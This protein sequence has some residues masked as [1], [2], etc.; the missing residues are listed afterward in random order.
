MSARYGLTLSDRAPMTSQRNREALC[1]RQSSSRHNLPR[2]LIDPV[3]ALAV[4]L[5]PRREMSVGQAEHKERTACKMAVRR[6][7]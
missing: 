2:L 7:G 1:E 5:V 3:L 6:G 4:V